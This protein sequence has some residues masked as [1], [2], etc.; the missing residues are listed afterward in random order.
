MHL[1]K[2]TVGLQVMAHTATQLRYDHFSAVVRQ[3]FVTRDDN[4]M[5]IYGV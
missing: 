5:Q 1:H 3:S 4:R 2:L